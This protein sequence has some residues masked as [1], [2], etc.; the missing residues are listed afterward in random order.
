MLNIALPPLLII[1]RVKHALCYM[2]TPAKWSRKIKERK[3]PVVLHVAATVFP[4]LSGVPGQLFS[5]ASWQGLPFTKVP[6]RFAQH[7]PPLPHCPLVLPPFTQ[8]TAAQSPCVPVTA[9]LLTSLWPQTQTRSAG[10]WFIRLFINF[11][12]VLTSIC[13]WG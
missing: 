8:Q 6:Q 13:Q 11:A 9:L 2:E 12:Q 5:M 10:T 1:P 4:H 7:P 3:S